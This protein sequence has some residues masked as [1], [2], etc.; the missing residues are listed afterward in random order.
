MSVNGAC[1]G[2]ELLE[3]HPLPYKELLVDSVD[4]YDGIDIETACATSCPSMH[5]EG[6]A[7][8]TAY[9][10]RAQT[11]KRACARPGL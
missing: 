3:T 10:F 4:M 11:C 1:V 7:Q 9:N 8:S 6:Q 5:A 2:S